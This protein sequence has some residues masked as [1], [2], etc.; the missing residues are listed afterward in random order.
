ME[1]NKEI[2]S[3]IIRVKLV[4]GTQINGQVNIDRGAA[5]YD[6]LSD[7]LQSR[8]EEFIVVVGATSH[9]KDLEESV[10]HGVMF[11]NKRHILWAMPDY[12]QG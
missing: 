2:D 12:D 10:R 9:Q 7:L 8:D 1:Q 6:R 4:D 11:I 3:R 5:G